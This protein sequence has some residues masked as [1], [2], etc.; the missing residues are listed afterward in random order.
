M[1][2]WLYVSC[3]NSAYNGGLLIKHN[4]GSSRW[5]LIKLFLF[6]GKWVCLL[7][8]IHKIPKFLKFQNLIALYNLILWMHLST[9]TIKGQGNFKNKQADLWVF[10]ILYVYPHIISESWA[11]VYFKIKKIQVNWFC[12]CLLDFTQICFLFLT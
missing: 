5:T 8:K 9:F 4:F 12:C 7:R 11:C 2:I 10:I 3:S 1:S 6:K